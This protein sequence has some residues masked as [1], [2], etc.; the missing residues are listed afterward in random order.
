MSAHSKIGASSMHRWR[1]CPGSVRLSQ[2]I[3][4][5]SSVYAEEGTAAHALAEQC[6]FE[7]TNPGAL[8]DNRDM[9]DAVQ[10]YIDHVYEL[11]TLAG[12]GQRLLEH[13]FHLA[14]IHP[15]LFGTADY[16]Y[17]AFK[18]RTLYVRDYKHGAGVPVEVTNSDQLRY[19]ATGALLSNLDWRPAWIDIGI[20]QP[21]CPHP[22]G[23]IR[24]QRMSVVDLLEFIEE[25]TAAVQATE[26]PDAPCVTGDWCRWCPAAGICP[27]LRAK[28]NAL[29]AQEFRDDCTYD[30]AALA[31]ALD[32]VPLV[33]AW[34]KSV[35]EFAYREAEHGRCPPRY[36]LVDKVARRRWKS[37][38][39]TVEF[40]RMMGVDDVD[41]FEEPSVRSVAQ[42]EKKV[43]KDQ[44]A[45]FAPLVTQESSGLALVHESDKRQ[46]AKADAASEFA[47][48][49]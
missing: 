43:G 4:S 8:T 27:T 24:T 20:V 21:R 28:A 35:R 42:L 30:P 14:D 19:Y 45:L 16:V 10:V 41:I 3:E 47:Q 18:S 39:D 25:L 5:K 11:E 38:A 33:E 2:G 23:P 15:D 48:A 49:G 37:E 31:A 22:D 6:L 7:R 26:A 12:R 36:K 13:R 29:A 9:S 40:F 1:H 34:A 32:E 44:R 46:P 17:Y